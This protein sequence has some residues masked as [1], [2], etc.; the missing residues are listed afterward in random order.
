MSRRNNKIIKTRIGIRKGMQTMT[1]I[2]IWLLIAVLLAIACVEYKEAIAGIA[3]LSI[4]ILM[5]VYFKIE[6]L[7]K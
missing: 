5:V 2:S 7:I 3:L 1:K 4:I 6:K